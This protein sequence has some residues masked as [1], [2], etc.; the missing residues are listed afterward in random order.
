MNLAIVIKRSLAVVGAICAAWIC[1]SALFAFIMFVG[2]FVK[3]VH[4][5]GQDAMSQMTAA[6]FSLSLGWMITVIFLAVY[7]MIYIAW[8]K[9]LV[10]KWFSQF[11][12][13]FFEE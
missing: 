6:F 5:D 9:K 8:N 4:H 7:S 3:T 2:E 13:K 11:F 10:E 12:D 1:V